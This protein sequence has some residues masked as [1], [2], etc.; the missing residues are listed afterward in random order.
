MLKTDFNNFLMIISRD[1]SHIRQE[2]GR[3]L[4]RSFGKGETDGSAWLPENYEMT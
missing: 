4:R 3:K 1:M 2:H